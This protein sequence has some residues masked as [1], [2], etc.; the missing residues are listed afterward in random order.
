LHLSDVEPAAAEWSLI[1]LVPGPDYV[2]ALAAP[3]RS[4]TLVCRTLDL[5][6]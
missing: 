4:I 6:D 3:A 5:A 2:G 1:D